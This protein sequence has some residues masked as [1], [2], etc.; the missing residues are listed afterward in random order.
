[1]NG[2]K[3]KKKGVRK[4]ERRKIKKKKKIRKKLKN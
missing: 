3:K 2:D 1:V 4:I